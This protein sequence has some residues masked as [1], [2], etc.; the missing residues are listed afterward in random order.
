MVACLPPP[1]AWE[2]AAG[3]L[4]GLLA[5]GVSASAPPLARSTAVARVASSRTDLLTFT[6]FL[7]SGRK[8]PK[9]PAPACYSRPSMGEGGHRRIPQMNYLCRCLELLAG[10]EL[11]RTPCLRSSERLPSTRS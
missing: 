5:L 3:C 7:Y 1:L 4:P 9:P 8:I 11:L 6:T 2:S 10:S